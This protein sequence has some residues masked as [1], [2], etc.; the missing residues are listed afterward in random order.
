MGRLTVLLLAILSI[1][2]LIAGT[3]VADRLILIPTGTTLSTGDF[4][5]EYAGHGSAQAYWA[6]VGIT[7][8]EVEGAWFRNFGSNE[9][10][11]VSAQ[12]AV[13]PETSFTPAL[14]VGVRDIGD[15][16]DT[17]ALLYDGRSAY[18]AVSKG[19]ET[20]EGLTF[21][22]DLK[23]HAGIGTGSLSGIFFGAEVTLPGKVR[24]AAEYD[25]KDFN[26]AA[27]YNVAPIAKLRVSS[28]HDEGYYGAV[29]STSF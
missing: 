14:G 27:T 29:I 22:Q 1:C 24:L 19:V 4:R 18:V 2:C 13:L 26:F 12:I 16:A 15:S 17:S 9:N 3:A 20:G 10:G 21:V 11:A 7:R 23:A 28:I 25:T 8:L 5:A 6:A